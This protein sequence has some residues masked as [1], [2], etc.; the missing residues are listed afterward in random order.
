MSRVPAKYQQVD[1]LL[2][3]VLQRLPGRRAETRA[4]VAETEQRMKQI[5]EDSTPSVG[6]AGYD[7]DV[8]FMPFTP[9]NDPLVKQAIRPIRQEWYAEYAGLDRELKGFRRE[10]V[11]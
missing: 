11:E 9:A 3:Y 7:P 5:E 8:I 6:I 2:R 4:L 10:L 1:Q